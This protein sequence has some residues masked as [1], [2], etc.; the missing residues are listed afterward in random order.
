[1]FFLQYSSMTQVFTLY[2][3]IIPAIWL[4]KEL[5]TF[6]LKGRRCYIGGLGLTD[7]RTENLMIKFFHR[8]G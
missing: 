1:M 3:P 4:E 5:C 6:E 8:A 2:V 7:V